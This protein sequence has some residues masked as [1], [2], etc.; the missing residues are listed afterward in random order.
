MIKACVIGWP[1]THSRSP[2]IHGFW[3]RE[4]GISGTYERVG[5]EPENLRD[6]IINL[7]AKGFAGCNVTLPHK[8]AALPFINH[9][10]D[11]VKAIGA[12]NTV[13]VRDG[14][15]YATSTD[16]DGFLENLLSHVPDFNP[17]GA[18]V[19]ILGAGGS[20]KAIIERLLRANVETITVANRTLSRAQDLRNSFG[21]KIVPTQNLTAALQA[22]DLLINTTSQGMTGQSALEINL[23]PLRKSAIVCDIV[24]V[25]LKTDL[26]RRAQSRGHRTVPGL[27]MLLHQAVAGFALWFGQKPIVTPELYT[28]IAR[29]IDKAYQP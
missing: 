29:D 26:I 21:P 5:V 7:S 4:L 3:L 22:C 8:E 2:L 6:F 16:G 23:E 18:N 12:L 19:T 11:R 25:P 14:K 13:Y 15:T 28:L 1:V 10:D 9:L 17:A 20:A 27:G 24:Y